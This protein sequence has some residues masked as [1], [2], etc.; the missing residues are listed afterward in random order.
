MTNV[1]TIFDHLLTNINYTT[2]QILKPERQWNLISSTG[3]SEH[4]SL[5]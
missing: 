3:E 4:F 2:K 5:C 1:F